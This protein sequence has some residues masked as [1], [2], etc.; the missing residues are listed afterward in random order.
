MF[1]TFSVVQTLRHM[2][3]IKFTLATLTAGDL[4]LAGLFIS[5]CSPGSFH[6]TGKRTF[7][8]LPSI[9]PSS[10]SVHPASEFFNSALFFTPVKH[11]FDKLSE[12]NWMKK[13]NTYCF[14]FCSCT[15]LL[16]KCLIFHWLHRVPGLSETFVYVFGKIF[17]S[18]PSIVFIFL[19]RLFIQLPSS[20]ALQNHGLC[21]GRRPQD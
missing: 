17:V 13:T 18:P 3:S 14:L 9:N 12:V 10:Q 20:F 7:E 15:S 8:N 16:P 1:L 2:Y 21:I 4:R 6:R 5:S 11:P 19:C